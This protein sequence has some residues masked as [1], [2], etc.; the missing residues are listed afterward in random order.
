[1][2]HRRPV[3]GNLRSPTKSRSVWFRR[4]SRSR[5]RERARS[6]HP[7]RSS[8][9]RTSPCRRERR[10]PRERAT[11]PTR[12]GAERPRAREHEVDA[13]STT[14]ADAM[15]RRPLEWRR[16][17]RRDR[18]RRGA[19]R[20]RVVRPPGRARELRRARAAGAPRGH[21]VVA[22]GARPRPPH[23]GRREPRAPRP[24]LRLGSGLG[25]E[26]ARDRRRGH[27]L[28]PRSRGENTRPKRAGR[29]P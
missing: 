10:A 11:S 2:R 22:R 23:R 27:R 19:R 21:R 29:R 9:R 15:E 7:D 12:P 25:L 1:M 24:D 28:P 17:S 5:R 4:P 26:V 14:G 13:Q 16:A 8:R 20:R 6:P 3:R 18:A